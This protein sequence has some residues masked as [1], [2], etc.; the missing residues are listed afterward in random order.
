MAGQ[1]IDIFVS[2]KAEDRARVARLVAALEAEGFSLWWDTHIGGGTHWREDIEEHLEGA[3]C[4]IVVWSR[5][6]VGREGN[7]VRDEATRAQ[8]RGAYLPVRIDPVDPPLG[9]GE[10]QALSLVRWKGDPSDPRLRAVTDAARACIAGEDISHHLHFAE[11]GVSRRTAIAGGAVAAVAIAGAAAWELLKPSTA[12]AAGS[13]AVLPFANLSGD[14]AQSYFSDGIS[15]EIRS[16]LTRLRGLTVIGSTSSEAVRNDDA[17]T[18]AKKLGVAHILTGNVRK[19]PSTIRIAAELID[20]R[21]GADRWTQDYDRNPGDT[22]KI[23][24]DIAENVASALQGALGL[25]VRAAITLGGTADPVAQD[26]ILQ[27]KRLSRESDSAETMH[28]TLALAE[29][30]IARDPNYADAYI[31][32]A[33]NLVNLTTNYAQTPAKTA[34]GLAQAE[35]DARKA[36]ALAPRLGSAHV[37]LAHV[38]SNSLDFVT[39]LQETRRSLALAPDDPRALMSAS[40]K[41]ALFGDGAEAIGFIDRAIELDPLNEVAYSIKTDVLA[42][43]RRYPQAIET[44]RKALAMAPDDSVVRM[45]IGDAQLLLGQSANAKAEYEG[46]HA[47][48]PFRLLRLALLAARTGDRAGAEGTIEQMKQQIGAA[49]SYQYSEIYAQLGDKDR[50]FAELDNAVRARDPGLSSVKVDPFLD[51]IR[52]DPRYAALLRRLNFPA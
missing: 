25:A 32:K 39:C 40:E 42:L 49:G 19:S 36:V 20:G 33:T 34:D 2:Y 26:L 15:D 51:P 16:A 12:A 38:A 37:A 48:D 30:A 27:A 31:S 41:L 17:R 13:I 11:R 43:L 44:G 23:Q 35:A 22:I 6:S 10:I 18:A 46:L 24:T 47:D 4:V 28:R 21:T 5:R 50:A 14:P 3:K 8:R 45:A 1:P 9:F 7:F 29:A 52:G